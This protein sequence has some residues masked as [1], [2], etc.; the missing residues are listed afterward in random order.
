MCGH[1]P[2]F[3]LH[4]FAFAALR[5]ES[6]VGVDFLGGVQKLAALAISLRVQWLETISAS[7]KKFLEKNLGGQ[8]PVDGEDCLD[9]FG[10]WEVLGNTRPWCFAWTQNG[11][12]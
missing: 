10:G 8:C 2:F 3:L 5:P 12:D 9:E 1:V 7:E 4:R 11:A 6:I